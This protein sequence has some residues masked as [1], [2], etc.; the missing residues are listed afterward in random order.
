MLAWRSATTAAL[1]QTVIQI[2]ITPVWRVFALETVCTTRFPSHPLGSPAP[3]NLAAASVCG[4]SQGVVEA[5][6]QRPRRLSM[7]VMGEEAELCRFHLNG[8]NRCTAVLR[9]CPA[10]GE[11][12]IIN[13][14]G[15]HGSFRDSQV[16]P[17]VAS[18]D[19]DTLAP[20]RSRS[21]GG[22]DPTAWL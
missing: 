21:R 2:N 10:S 7:S 17:R 13:Q 22:N 9:V 12:Q 16:V 14:Q 6:L 1:W 8:S 3:C 19:A 15:N 4:T 20:E 18:Q 5:E 11:A